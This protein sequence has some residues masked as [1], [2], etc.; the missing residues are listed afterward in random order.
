MAR[1]PSATTRRSTRAARFQTINAGFGFGDLDK[2]GFN[3][4]GFG[5]Y[6]KQDA[7]DGTQRDFNKRIVG[8]LSYSTSPANVIQDGG[9]YNP[10]LPNCS[11]NQVIKDANGDCRIVTPSFVDFIPQ[12]E[13]ASGMIKGTFK[14]NQDLTLGAEIFASQNRVTTAIAPVPY[15]GYLINPGTAYYPKNAGLSPTFNGPHGNDGYAGAPAFNPTSAFPHPV[16]VEPG[17][18][19]LYWRDFPNGSRVQMNKNT[20]NRELLTAKAPRSVG[21]TR[22]RRPTTPTRSTSTSPEA[23]PTAT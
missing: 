13:T 9:F 5:S 14:V 1:S 19:Y 10:T 17:Y 3:I 18:A 23:M 8:G 16:N 7:I 20:Q 22:S 4:F 11:G 6:R 15:G 12:S 21:I 2:Q